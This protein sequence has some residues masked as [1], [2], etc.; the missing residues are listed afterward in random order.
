M[1]GINAM[2][3]KSFRI[4]AAV[5]AV[6]MMVLSFASCSFTG[7]KEEE[8]EIT[9]NPYGIEP[10]ED[11]GPMIDFDDFDDYNPS[12]PD[13]GDKP[14]PSESKTEPTGQKPSA[15]KPAP[16]KPAATKPS[17][18][19]PSTSRP[20]T[21]EPDI[22]GGATDS[23]GNPTQSLIDIVRLA[24]YEYDAQEKCFYSTLDPWQRH[25]GFGEEYDVAAA[26]LTMIYTTIKIDF[27]YKD[28]LWRIQCWK[29]NYGVLYGGEMGVY[30]KDPNDN[31]TTYYQCASDEDMLEM[32]FKHYRTSSDFNN[33]K[34]SF[35]RPLQKH[36]WLTGFKF[37]YSDPKY[38][39]LEMTILAKD[40]EMADG[41]EKGLQNV[42]DNSGRVNGFKQYTANAKGS[43]FYIRNGNEFKIIWLRAGFENYESGTNNQK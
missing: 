31:T 38:A 16:S 7:S 41:I 18:T 21:T 28:K 25:F 39:V 2:K 9:K 40:K 36:W 14:A 8:P 6:V 12:T 10:P 26:Y 4:I 22:P 11:D 43:D 34:P 15:T 29:G 35:T 20:T 37:G 32:S 33:K 5:L 1:E 17:A 23:S 3:T 27:P 13:N 30:T 24:G 42:K 19:K